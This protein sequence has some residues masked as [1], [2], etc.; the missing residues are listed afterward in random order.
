MVVVDS[1]PPTVATITKL[2][3]SARRRKAGYAERVIRKVLQEILYSL[4]K[5]RVAFYVGNETIAAKLCDKL[6]Y[7]GLMGED[8]NEE[9]EECLEVGF[10]GIL[11]GYC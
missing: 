6:Q 1:I 7:Q 5:Q 9:V 8:D 4:G 3:T 10:K 11:R 2:H